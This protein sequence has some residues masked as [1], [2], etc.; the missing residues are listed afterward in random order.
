MT[1]TGLILF[2][3]LF[4]S[5]YCVYIVYIGF[6]WTLLLSHYHLC[7]LKLYVFN[8]PI[9]SRGL[10]GSSY[11][12]ANQCQSVLNVCIVTQLKEQQQQSAYVLLCTLIYYS[13]NV[14]SR[15]GRDRMV[16]GFTTTY[17]ISAYHHWSCEFE[18]RSWRDVLQY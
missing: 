11:C 14:G 6:I 3:Y 5:L 10:S 15:R 4:I 9:W 8:F 7:Y 16:T 2:I 13:C 18:P 17:A 12:K 1:K